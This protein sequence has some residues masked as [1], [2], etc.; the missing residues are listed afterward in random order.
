MIIMLLH[1]SSYM[2]SLVVVGILG[3]HT[4]GGSRM[5]PEVL[6]LIIGAVVDESVA[7]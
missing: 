3:K 6:Y 7:V 2:S 1:H 5:R 4:G